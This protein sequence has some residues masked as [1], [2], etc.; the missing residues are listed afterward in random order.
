M[1]SNSGLD[2]HALKI[3]SLIFSVSLWFYVLN[4]EP[5]IIERKVELR[6]IAP[7]GKAINNLL[8]KE[9]SVKVKGSRAFV[10]D[11]F[12]KNEKIGIDLHSYPHKAGEP[13]KVNIN[14]SDIPV[15]F[16][17]DV[18]K[19]MPDIIL[20]ELDRE[21]VKEVP[22]KLST[23]KSVPPDL[24]LIDQNLSPAKVF[25]RGPY[26]IMKKTSSVKTVPVDLSQLEGEGKMKVAIGEVDPRLQVMK[27]ETVTYNYNVKPRKANST[28]QK[29]RIRFLSSSRNFYPSIRFASI[30]VLL[31]EEM[32][33]QLSKDQIQIIADVPEGSSGKTSDVKLKAILPKGVHLLQ[34]YPEFIKVR[35]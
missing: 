15:P 7:R 32:K 9:I 14:P 34:I 5:L 21:I 29:I 12:S 20:V 16:G 35:L 18:I 17:V 28:V 27:L 30:D 13:I 22:F 3:I 4:S 24:K 2:K 19:I 10:K 33:G 8:P 26:S 25:I 6:L 31:P 1:I 11:L 23:L